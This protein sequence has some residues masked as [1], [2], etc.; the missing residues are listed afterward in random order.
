MSFKRERC[1]LQ[2]FQTNLLKPLNVHEH[3]HQSQIYCERKKNPVAVPLSTLP[4]KDLQGEAT[5]S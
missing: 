2:K 4:K 3:S 5:A 1:E